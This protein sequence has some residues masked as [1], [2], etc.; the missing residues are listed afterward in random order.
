MFGNLLFISMVQFHS[1]LLLF[2]KKT[3]KEEDFRNC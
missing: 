2:E 3:K 1:S